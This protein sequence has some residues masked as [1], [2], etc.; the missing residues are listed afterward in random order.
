MIDRTFGQYTI[1]EKI[2]EGGMGEVFRAKDHVLRREVALKF[3]PESM[4]QD[5]TARRRFLREARSAAALDHPYICQIYEIGEVDSV[6]FIALRV[7][8]KMAKTKSTARR[9]G[10]EQR[11]HKY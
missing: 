1:E 10:R 2:G 9:R 8:T 11:P 6:G 3:L 4:A 5:E 7:S